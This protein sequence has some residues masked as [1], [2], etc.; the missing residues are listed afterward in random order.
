MSLLRLSDRSSGA[1]MLAGGFKEREGF[2]KEERR[3]AQDTKPFSCSVER[4][5]HFYSHFLVEKQAQRGQVSC[6]GPHS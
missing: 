5:G 2:G 1:P 4:D 3:R 6:L